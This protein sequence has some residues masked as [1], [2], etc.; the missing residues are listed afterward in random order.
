MNKLEDEGVVCAGEPGKAEPVLEGGG[1]GNQTC[2]N[3]R[4]MAHAEFTHSQHS[5]VPH[6]WGVGITSWELHD[7]RAWPVAAGF[8]AE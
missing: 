5:P 1:G 7:Q 2:S 6:S 8:V 3:E 4:F